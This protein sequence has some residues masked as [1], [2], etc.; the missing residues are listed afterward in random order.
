MLRFRIREARGRRQEALAGAK[1]DLEKA[2]AGDEARPALEF[3]LGSR[4]AASLR[5]TL[6]GRPVGRWYVALRGC[7]G[8]EPLPLPPD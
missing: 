7:E 2:P 1:A 6:A 8:L 4:D 3:F 5:K